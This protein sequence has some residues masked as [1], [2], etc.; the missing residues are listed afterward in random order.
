[1]IILFD[2]NEFTK[3]DEFRIDDWTLKI[4]NKLQKNVSFFSTK[5]VKIEYVQNLID[6]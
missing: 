3:K 4:E 6:D 1:M 5:N 2:S